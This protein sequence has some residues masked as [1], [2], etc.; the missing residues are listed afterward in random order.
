MI[1]QTISVVK[2]ISDKCSLPIGQLIYDLN[3]EYANAN[4]QDSGSIAEIYSEECVR[5]RMVPAIGF[6]PILNNFYEQIVDG[7]VTICET[8]NENP[9]SSAVDIKTFLN[10]S[11]DEPDKQ[12]RSLHNRWQIRVAI[13]KV[14]LY[15]AGFDSEMDYKISF[16]A[17]SEVKQIVDA[18][19][20]NTSDLTLEQ[21]KEWFLKA[22]EHRKELFSSSGKLW[23]EDDC[24]SMLNMIACKNSEDRYF[25]GY[26]VLL[27]ARMYH[28]K[29]RTVDVSHEIFAVFKKEKANIEHY[30]N[31]GAYARLIEDFESDLYESA[32]VPIALAQKYTAISLQPGGKILDILVQSAIQP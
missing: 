13:Y 32:V 18:S 25:N 4:Q 26:K 9:N 24:I 27:G 1:K 8:I 21:A 10:T 7:Y 14:L 29:E 23:L 12:D 20:S 16:P 5:Y 11:F 30:S 2:N 15:T 3:G 22:R 19:V 31:I 28:T 17:N 6:Q